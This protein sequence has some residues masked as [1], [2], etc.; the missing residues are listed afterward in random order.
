MVEIGALKALT[1][2]Y[3]CSTPLG[4]YCWKLD[5]LNAPQW[6][7]KALPNK[8]DFANSQTTV[9]PDGFLHIDQASDLLRHTENPFV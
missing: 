6:Q 5:P 2:F 4:I 3:I 1:A 9:R 7:M 8:T